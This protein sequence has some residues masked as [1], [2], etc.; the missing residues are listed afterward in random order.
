M[1]LS[2]REKIL[3]YVLALLVIL[4]ASWTYII[5]PVLNANRQAKLEYEAAQAEREQMEMLMPSLI[6]ADSR[7]SD[8]KIRALS[9]NYFY[10]NLIDTQIDRMLQQAAYDSGVTLTSVTI[11]P[12]QIGPVASSLA[13]SGSQVMDSA[14]ESA[15]SGGEN[16]ESQYLSSMTQTLYSCSITMNG[17]LANL[18][19]AINSFSTNG[20]SVTVDTFAITA[21]DSTYTA[22]VN[23]TFYFV[24]E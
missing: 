7:L 13:Y 9:D 19:N 14:L 23:M 11:N 3:L 1:V 12:A 22:D 18:I 4:L 15:Q 10:K 2:K 6:G 24:E 21:G 17:D 20:K 8:E 5:N 16:G